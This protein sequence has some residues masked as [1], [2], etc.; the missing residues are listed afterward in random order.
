MV[1]FS[2]R[3]NS[4]RPTGVRRM[5]DLAGDDAI[6][7]GLGEPDFQPPPLAIKAFSKAMEDGRNKYTTTAGLPELRKKI[8]ETW[9]H[10]DSDLD[11][12][13]VCI[14]MSGT[15]ALLDI[16]LALVN[17]GDNVLIPEPYFPLY[18]TDV[19]LCGGEANMYPCHFE[20]GFVPTI[21]DL[22]SRIN[23][24][25][26][27]ILYNF[28]SNPTGGNVTEEQ[29]DKLVKFA[30]ENDLWLITDEVYDKIIYDSEHVSFLGAGYEKV[31]MIN[32]FSK[33]FAMTGWRIG[34]L[35]SPDLEAMGQLTK[36]QYYVTA[37]SND[38]MQYAVLEA[39]EKAS[40]YPAEMCAEFKK[41]RD[42]ICSRLNSMPNVSCNI[43]TGAFYVFPKFDIPGYN[44]EELAMKMLEGGVLCSPGTAFG[45]AGEGHLRFAYTICQEDI[46]RGMDRV[47]DIILTLI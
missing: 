27:A 14:T 18:P 37:C 21:E 39:L 1:R 22:E 11:E 6:Q 13:N 34:Y 35:L 16:F 8:A 10:R 15:N 17:P 29:R 32:S 20:N 28:P 33:T 9:H 7:F 31:I 36:M 41:R 24:N 43:P 46:S 26:I 19:V 23:E 3:A 44:S 40:D 5:F 45:Q 42:L 12:S 2:D 25:T 4:I 38:A 30:Q 47:E